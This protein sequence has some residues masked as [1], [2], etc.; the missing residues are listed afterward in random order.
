MTKSNKN[1]QKKSIYITGPI[2]ENI[3][4]PLAMPILVD[5]SSSQYSY[6]HFNQDAITLKTKNSW[7]GILQSC[8]FPIN[9]IKFIDYDDLRIL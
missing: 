3:L 1:L 8:R 4:A 9:L 7:C 5:S 2:I 6:I